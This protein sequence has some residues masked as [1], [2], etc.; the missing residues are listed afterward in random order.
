MLK[1]TTPSLRNPWQGN[2]FHNIRQD[3]VI[4]D[5][6][7]RRGKNSKLNKT[8]GRKRGFEPDKVG[9]I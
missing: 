3:Y 8:D 4:G 9:F 2:K 7:S 6:S 5:G 1:K